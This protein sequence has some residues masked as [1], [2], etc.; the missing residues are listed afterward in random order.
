MASSASIPS[1]VELM[2]S[3]ITG[4]GVI[5]AITPGRWA[6]MPAAA[7]ITLMPRLLA[8]RANSSTSPGVRWAERAF[9]SNGIS[10]SS[11]NFAAFSSMGRSLVLPMIMLT[12]GFIN[13]IVYSLNIH[14]QIRCKIRLQVAKSCAARESSARWLPPPT[15]LSPCKW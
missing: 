10:I 12:I 15:G 7:I 2:G 5:A 6:A 9:I 4:S 8:L 11:K 13:I 3:P 1:R 14:T